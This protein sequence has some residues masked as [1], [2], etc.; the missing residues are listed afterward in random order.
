MII[1]FFELKKI[2]LKKIKFFLLYGNNTGLIEETCEKV[3]KPLKKSNIFNYDEN[4]ILKNSDEFE[5]TLSN[6]SFFDNEKLILINRATD[7]IFSII[8]KIINKDPSEVSIILISGALDK[9]SKIRN[10]FEKNE[11]T[12]IIPFY[13]DNF[14][15][16][17]LLTINFLK[18]KKISL[19]PQN[20]NLII[21]RSRGDRIN[22]LNELNKIE[23]FSKNK[24]NIQTED[25]LKLTNLSEN[26]NA[27]DLVDNTLAKNQKKTLYILNEN[28]FVAE[29]SILIL[30]TF[31]N[32]LKRLL[33]IRIEIEK[34]N[35]NID[36]VIS[37]YKPVI[38]WKEK[39]IVKKQIK[40][41]NLEKIQ[42]LLVKSN[43]LELSIKKN[44]LLSTNILTNFILEEVA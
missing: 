14:Q 32:K 34:N 29:D 9:R 4:E 12:A 3:I 26:F 40:N 35:R 20:I 43:N 38:F 28:N 30:R 13:E 17:N 1:K 2:N 16:L 21:E 42:I 7:K 33:K 8:E 44:P 27:A 15:S 41:L 11:K 37:E 39:D 5:E 18:E 36:Q 22:L 10:F 23:Y 6:K 25:I 19:S 24:K 31:I